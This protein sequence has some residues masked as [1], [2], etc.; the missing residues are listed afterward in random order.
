MSAYT[1]LLGDPDSF[2]IDLARFKKLRRDDIVAAGRRT[3]TR[4]R[5]LLSVVP[6]GHLEQA[7]INPVLPA[8]GGAR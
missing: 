8:L 2:A 4:G 7:V 5:L 3:L 6:R 1:M